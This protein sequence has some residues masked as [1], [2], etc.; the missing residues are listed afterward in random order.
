VK[1]HEEAQG[2][3][4]GEEAFWL[5]ISLRKFLEAILEK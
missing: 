5:P 2:L 1:E 3:M 4:G